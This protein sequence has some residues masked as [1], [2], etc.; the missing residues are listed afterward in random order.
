MNARPDTVLAELAACRARCEAL[1]AEN[2]WLKE[3]A[4]TPDAMR[5]LTAAL[6]VPA[7][8][9]R[10]LHLLMSRQ[11]VSH[12]VINDLHEPATGNE[13][14]AAKYHHVVV[15]RLRRGL[16]PRDL[17]IETIKSWG[18][19]MPAEDRARLRAMMEAAA[20]A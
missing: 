11:A 9:G 1:E 19:R 6:G 7:W 20:A 14:T 18:Y 17:R 15:H 12:D 4:A 3:Q 16:R 10:A 8:C 5:L 2:D 13:K